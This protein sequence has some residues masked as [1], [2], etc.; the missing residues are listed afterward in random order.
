VLQPL[1]DHLQAV[2]AP[3]ADDLAGAVTHYSALAETLGWRLG[4]AGGAEASRRLL[5]ERGNVDV[6]IGHGLHR[7]DPKP[8]IRAARAF[9][10]FMRYWGVGTPELLEVAADTASEL[11]DLGLQA[12]A[13]HQLGMVALQRSDFD[14][15]QAR[16]EEAQPLYEQVGNLL[17][18][19]NCIRGLGA[20]ALGRS[21]YDTAKA[22]YEEALTLYQRIP[23]LPSAESVRRRLAQLL[24]T[25]E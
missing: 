7:N 8:A 23:D 9:S 25:N 14:T 5:I 2:H 24:A 6:M 13:L 11:G 3:R 12:A 19:A 1:R 21:D 18:Q 20:V 10:E 4:G 22:R 16:Y 15:A 17:G